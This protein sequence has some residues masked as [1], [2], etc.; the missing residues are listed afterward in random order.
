MFL[1]HLPVSATVRML[2]IPVL[3]AKVTHY[4]ITRFAERNILLLILWHIFEWVAKMVLLPHLTSVP[5][6]PKMIQHPS[7]VSQLT[8][9]FSAI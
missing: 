6:S 9:A 2:G 8:V 4:I 1:L 3:I 5:R 7:V